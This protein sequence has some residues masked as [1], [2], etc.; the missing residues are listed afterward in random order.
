MNRWMMI[1]A[2]ATLL[3]TAAHADVTGS[4][5]A[6]AGDVK[7]GAVDAVHVVGDKSVAAYHAAKSTAK[8][9]AKTVGR[10]AEKA[11]KVVAAGAKAGAHAVGDTAVKGYDATKQ[12]VERASTAPDDGGGKA[13]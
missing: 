5:R 1:L 7:T 13:K 2:V 9:V 11:G 3:S 4:A 12:A 8:D 6:A 10:G